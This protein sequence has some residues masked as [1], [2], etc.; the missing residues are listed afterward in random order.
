MS[1]MGSVTQWIHQ[2]KS[3]DRA[4]VQN[5]WERYCH[6]IVALARQVLRLSSRAVADEED[7]ANIAFASFI[8]AVENDRFPKLDDR[9]DVWQVLIVITRRK[10]ITQKKKFGKP[11]PVPLPEEFLE[12]ISKEPDPE[13]VAEMVDQCRF[14][15]HKLDEDELRQ[16]ATW[17]MEEFTISAIAKKLNLSP[18]TIE[19]R[20][21]LI[22]KC[23]EDEL[24]S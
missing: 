21:R 19:R 2:L 6:R 22:R 8:K 14:L 11:G 18:S 5:L 13:F 12:L 15:L 7:V 10:A 23:W 1:E 17:K 9:N 24:P 16:I 4:K 3:G 20:L